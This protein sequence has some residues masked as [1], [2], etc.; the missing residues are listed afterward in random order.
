MGFLADIILLKADAHSDVTSKT[1]AFSLTPAQHGLILERLC[2]AFTALGIDSDLTGL[3]STTAIDFQVNG[4]TY[5]ARHSEESYNV[6]KVSGGAGQIVM[7]IRS[8][9]VP[10]LAIYNIAGSKV[11]DIIVDNAIAT[12][13]TASLP[14]KSTA[15]TFAMTSDIAAASNFTYALA[16]DANYTVPGTHMFIELPVT[17]APRNIV[18]P[19]PTAGAILEFGNLSPNVGDWTFTTVTVQDCAGFALT[20]LNVSSGYRLMGNGVIWRRM[21]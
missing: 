19:P 6:T 1:V 16:P 4:V 5:R 11:V 17:T 9:N 20:L 2:D 7:G 8:G 18:L 13:Y 12:S 14:V 10:T 3:L 21:N 15:Q